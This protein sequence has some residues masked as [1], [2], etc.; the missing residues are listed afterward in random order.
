MI[1]LKSAVEILNEFLA[2]LF[3][4]ISFHF[5]SF[6]FISLLFSRSLAKSFYSKYSRYIDN[7]AGAIFLFFGGY[8]VYSGVLATAAAF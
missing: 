8:L 7:L 1:L 4:I 5:I 3:Y 2:A 6:H